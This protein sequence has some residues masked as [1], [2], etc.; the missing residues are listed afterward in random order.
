MCSYKTTELKKS[1]KESIIGHPDNKA[2][3]I[4]EGNKIM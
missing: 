1:K 4:E 3:I 2:K